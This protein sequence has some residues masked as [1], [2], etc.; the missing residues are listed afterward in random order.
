ML[1]VS[2]EVLLDMAERADSS[3]EANLSLAG[4]MLNAT[5]YILCDGDT[6]FD[7]GIDDE[8]I[9]MPAE[10]WLHEYKTA[11]WRIDQ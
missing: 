2:S 8:E 5:H 7:L 9:E 3:I 11:T 6:V 1:F 4:G 10:A